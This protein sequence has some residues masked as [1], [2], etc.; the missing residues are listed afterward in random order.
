MQL[1]I[2]WFIYTIGIDTVFHV[3]ALFYGT[4]INILHFINN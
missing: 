3:V 1:A 4:G 2:E